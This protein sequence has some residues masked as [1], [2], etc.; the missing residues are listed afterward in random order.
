MYI[1]S[2]LSAIYDRLKSYSLILLGILIGSLAAALALSRLSQRAISQP[3]LRLADMAAI[4]S[5]DKD[6]SIRAPQVGDHDEV[7]RF[8]SMRSMK[9]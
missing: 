3:I 5:R 7:S 6:Y 9:C 8:S 2:D 1:Q 4:V